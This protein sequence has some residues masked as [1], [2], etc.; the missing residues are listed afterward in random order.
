[1]KLILPFKEITKEDSRQFGG[2]VAS[3]GEISRSG[4]PVPDGFGISVEAYRL[5][6]GK[7]FT[8]EFKRELKRAF[9]KLGANR[10]AVRSSAAAEDAAD[11]SWAGQLQ[12]FLNVT[13]P[14]LEESIRKCWKSME[15][16]NV[17]AYTKGK[18]FS[19]EDLLVGVGV[20]AM[21]ES[22]AA[23]VMF[24]ANPVTGDRDELIIE[25]AYG[26]GEMVVQG[27]V[28]PDRHMVDSAKMQVSQF[29][30]QIKE[31]MMMYKDGRNKIIEV[32]EHKADKAVLW[33]DEVIKL[34]KLGMK[35]ARH[36]GSPQD[37]EWAR[38][39]GKYYIVQAR[40]ITTL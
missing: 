3:L 17:K 32:P 8:E 11:A 9:K 6:K 1:M 24:T 20:Q 14:Q 34:A 36:Y 21:V 27:A 10:V 15:S 35:I 16:G 39:R 22:E 26:L 33:E 29:D 31:K 13:F 28:T 2:K 12:T 4:I 30:I 37:I 5:F 19:D 23:G 18:H 40:P 38:H 7:P 25:S